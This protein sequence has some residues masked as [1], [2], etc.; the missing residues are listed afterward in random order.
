MSWL[1]IS[2]QWVWKYRSLI[3]AIVLYDIISFALTHKDFKNISRMDFPDPRE[4]LHARLCPWCYIVYECFIA[5]YLFF[6]G[7]CWT[8]TP[9]LV[10]EEPN[11]CTETSA[12]KISS[13]QYIGI[14]WKDE[15]WRHHSNHVLYVY[16]LLK[17]DV[18]L[19]CETFFG[20]THFPKK[21]IDILQ[22]RS[23]H[24]GTYICEL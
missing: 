16:Y 20:I 22:W 3:Y 18:Y 24:E 17:L 10:S 4:W 6:N 2:F 21:L 13:T 7:S 9:E 11:V 19:W 5:S 8:K 15:S 14:S 23:K 12:I 1:P